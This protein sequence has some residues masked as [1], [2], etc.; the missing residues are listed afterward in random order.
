M[1]IS[2]V[3]LDGSLRM[4]TAE[5]GTGDPLVLVG[6]GLTG[7]ASWEPH[8]AQL[9]G[10]RRTL[11]LQLLSVQSG[12]ED[13]ALPAN[14]S[15]KTESRAMA[16]AL[17]DLGLRDPVD[18]VAWSFGGMV[19]LDFALDRP[20]RVRTLTLIEPPALWVLPDHGRDDPEVL[21]M[22]RLFAGFG[23]D[24]SEGD[25]EGW[26]CRV[27][28]CPP[29][30]SARDLPQWPVWVQHRRSLRNSSVVFDHSDD[31]RRLP[32]FQRPVLLV[33]GTGTAPF[34]RRI[35]EALA[36]ELPRARTLEL[37]AG[38]AP[39]IVSMDRFLEELAEFQG[40]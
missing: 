29:D 34:L 16:A 24:I 33:T 12:L 10:M 15:L 27:G 19:T 32:G 4:Q 26:A 28:L 1:A 8:V 18:L 6:G 35:H 23:D 7:W 14:Y 30:R 5:I 40:R 17:D 9:S 3:P 39:H 22:E 38:H 36:R 13:R 20:E 2:D 25:L 37:P 31:P 11:R 21:V